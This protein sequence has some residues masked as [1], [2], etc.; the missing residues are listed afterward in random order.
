MGKAIRSLPVRNIHKQQFQYQSV[1]ATP[2]PETVVVEAQPTVAEVVQSPQEP[3]K[4]PVEDEPV[5]VE[6]SLPVQP[7]TN[8]C[9]Y[10]RPLVEKY[11]GESTNAAMLTMQKESGCNPNAVG[12][13]DDHG[14]FQL[15]SQ[16]IYDPETNI[17]VAYQKYVHAR[18]GSHNFSAW[19]AVCTPD[20]VPKYSG[21]WCQ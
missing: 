20:L 11:F 18:R 15:H 17:A 6:A 1:G 4:P 19:Y 8:P 5:I 2:Q 3:V 10:F 14:L 13:T 7:E 9:G 16:P 12:P 21:I